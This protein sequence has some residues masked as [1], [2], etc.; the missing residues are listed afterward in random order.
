[1]H[2]YL[3]P[4][5]PPK[6]PTVPR[7]PPGAGQ[8]VQVSAETLASPKLLAVLHAVV[9]TDVQLLVTD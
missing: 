1:M 3:H 2:V 7:I 4:C 8:P 5:V 9:Q 6:W